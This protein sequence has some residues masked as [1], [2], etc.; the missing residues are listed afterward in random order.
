MTERTKLFTEDARN[1]LYDVI[2]NRRDVRGE[3]KSDPIDED[4]LA[5]ILIA[6]HHAPSVG[7]MQPWN[8]LLIQDPTVK[9]G[10]HQLFVKA[11]E[12]AAQKFDGERRDLYQSL[13]LEG[14]L[15]APLHICITCDRDRA[16]PNVLGR[17]HMHDMDLYSTVCAVQ[18]LWL[19]ARAENIGVGWV[20]IFH[21][22]ELK[23]LLNIPENIHIIAYLTVGHVSSFHQQPEL[24]KK[25]W[26]GRLNL[27]DLVMHNHW[28]T[29]ENNKLSKA[30]Q[31]HLETLNP[32]DNN[33]APIKTT[34]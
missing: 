8:F 21:E 2:F 5:R 9:N 10:V 24:A 13:K 7:F 12:E 3:F 16:G 6:A 19:A 22:T 30:I 25:G 23:Q 31:T 27:N 15:T 32:D 34:K 4:I 18:N 11:N 33:P 14:L 1:T 20:S 26:R 29:S 28:G 17:T